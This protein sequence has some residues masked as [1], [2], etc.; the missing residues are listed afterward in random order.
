LTPPTVSSTDLPFPVVTRGKVRDVYDLGDRLL[1]VATDR[2]SAFDVILPT[3]IS[4]KGAVLT[5]ISRFWFDLT[6]SICPNQTLT[7]PEAELPPAVADWEELHGRSVVV[8]KTRPFPVECVVRGYLSGSA[9]AAYRRAVPNSGVVELWGLRLPSGLKE[10]ERLPEPL[11][12]PT[13]KAHAGHD[14]SITLEQTADRI[15]SDTARLLKDRSLAVYVAGCRHA[16]SRGL[17]LA[18][19][20]FEFGER[21]GE[22]LLIDEVLTPD[23]SRFWDAETYAVGQPQPSFDKQ[24]VRDWLQDLADRGEW[25][26]EPPGPDLPEEIVRGTTERYLVAYRRITG[27]E[28]QGV[29]GRG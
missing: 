2:I 15:G 26:K 1:M 27:N 6:A 9:W 3:P 28:L 18:D 19:T 20:K 12:T 13:T 23:S 5:Q 29:G 14:E 21:D 17:I 11:F 8:K 7:G 24:Y 16:E 25:N 22:T 10:S 4:C